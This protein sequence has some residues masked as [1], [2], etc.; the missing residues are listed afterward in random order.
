MVVALV[1]VVLVVVLVVLVLVLVVVLHSVSVARLCYPRLQPPAL[2][3]DLV[4]I[5]AAGQAGRQ[6]GM[7]TS[8]DIS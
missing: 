2:V 6:G 1:L 5:L 4:I 8:S 3:L 7:Q